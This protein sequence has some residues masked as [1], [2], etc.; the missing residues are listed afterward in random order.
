[1]ELDGRLQSARS[2]HSCMRPKSKCRIG[3]WNVRAMFQTGKTAHMEGEMLLYRIDI[4][5]I[6]E[7]RWTG[8]SCVTTSLGKKIVY[9][10]RNDS[11]HR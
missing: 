2:G 7:C 5:S 3:T 4:L 8:N 1:M 6:S 10:G 11:D 9:A